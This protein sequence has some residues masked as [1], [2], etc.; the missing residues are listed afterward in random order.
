[1]TFESP[2]SLLGLLLLLPLIWLHLR[3]HRETTVRFPAMEILRRIVVRRHL[4]N[5]TRFLLLLILRAAVLCAFTLAAARPR[6]AV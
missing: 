5:R 4:E 1:M 6:I 2:F 3:R